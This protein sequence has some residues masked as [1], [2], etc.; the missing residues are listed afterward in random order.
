[1]AK[2]EILVSGSSQ[3]SMVLGSLVLFYSLLPPLT[4]LPGFQKKFEIHSRELA[5]P[6]PQGCVAPQ[7]KLAQAQLAIVRN[8]WQ[9]PPTPTWQGSGTIAGG[10]YRKVSTPWLT[11]SVQNGNATC[12][13]VA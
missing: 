9:V 11:D 4:P 7:A 13:G 5:S 6:S 12:E 3:P 1:M 8:Q 10:C 2:V